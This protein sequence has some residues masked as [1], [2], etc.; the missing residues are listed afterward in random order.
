MG[1]IDPDMWGEFKLTPL[2]CL[3]VFLVILWTYISMAIVK[4]ELMFCSGLPIILIV[5][6][7]F[8]KEE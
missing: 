7:I 5:Y 3:F 1:D 6:I 8:S 4:S 2:G